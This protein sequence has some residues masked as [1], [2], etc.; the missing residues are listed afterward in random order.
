MANKISEEQ[1]KQLQ[2]QVQKLNAIKLDLGT[3]EMQKHSLLH[4]SAQVLEEQEKLKQ[5]IETEHGPI[6]INLTDGSFEPVEQEAEVV[7]E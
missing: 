6:S 4:L 5:E 3:L 2:E 1:L 7:N